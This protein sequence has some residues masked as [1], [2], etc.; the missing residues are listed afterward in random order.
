MGLEDL[1]RLDGDWDN[2]QPAKAGGEYTVIPDDTKVKVVVS[3][4]KPSIVGKNQT[5]VCKVTFEV[6]APAEY[7]PK[8]IWHDFWLTPKN[9]PYL[10]RDLGILGW[11]GKPS[12]L[13]A[14]DDASLV[15]LGAEAT[16]GVEEYQP[17]DKHTGAPMVDGAGQ[18]VTRSKNTIKYFDGPYQHNAEAAPA[19]AGAAAP[20]PADKP[21]GPEDDIPF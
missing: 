16:V 9:L 18:P 14:S 12:Q 11:Q 13:L 2:T 8:P 19:D 3:D 4:Q 15:G 6:V 7:A 10:K 17:N 20:G 21:P 1:E 5:A